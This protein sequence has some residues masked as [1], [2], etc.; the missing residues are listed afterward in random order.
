MNHNKDVEILKN[1]ANLGIIISKVAE[2]GYI[3][4]DDKINANKARKFNT[5]AKNSKELLDAL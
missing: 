4:D 5:F 3:I 2:I 1:L